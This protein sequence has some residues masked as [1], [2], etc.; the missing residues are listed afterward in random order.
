MSVPE[1]IN[2]LCF[3]LA[4]LKDR[5]NAN[6]AT[7][8]KAFRETRYRRYRDVAFSELLGIGASS[9]RQRGSGWDAV[10]E[11]AEAGYWS[12]ELGR[13]D[14]S[15]R[16]RARAPLNRSREVERLREM[17]LGSKKGEW[18]T[19]AGLAAGANA[20][21][22][23]GRTQSSG[24]RMR[25]SSSI[26]VAETEGGFV[27]TCSDGE[28]VYRFLEKLATTWPE[29]DDEEVKARRVA[30][31]AHVGRSAL[32]D[33]AP[34]A[35]FV[36]G[37]ISI[38]EIAGRAPNVEKKRAGRPIVPAP[39][40][41]FDANAQVPGLSRQR[42]DSL[43]TPTVTP[44]MTPTTT[45][46]TE[47]AQARPFAYQPSRS[48]VKVPIGSLF[49]D[50]SPGKMTAFDARD[51]FVPE[52]SPRKLRRR[53]DEARRGVLD[54][55]DKLNV[56]LP[57]STAPLTSVT[58]FLGNSSLSVV[59]RDL[60]GTS[61]VCK[62]TDGLWNGEESEIA[63]EALLALGGVRS[64]LSKLRGRL[65][66][67]Q[68]LPRPASA[69]ILSCMVES[70][71][72]RYKVEDFAESI[73]KDRD[74][75][76][77]KDPIS[78]AFAHGLKRVLE[79]IDED[80]V[81][82]EMQEVNSWMQP[83]GL[84]MREG[85]EACGAEYHGLGMSILQLEHATASARRSLV[86]LASYIDDEGN[87]GD[88]LDRGES[89]E[90]GEV[91]KRH[92]ADS[93]PLRG[94]A[95]LESLHQIAQYP[96]DEEQ[97]ILAKRLFL[98]SFVPYLSLIS[99][100]AFGI[101][102]LTD[103]DPFV[104]PL[105]SEFAVSAL[106]DTLGPAC[107]PSFFSAEMWSD[108]MVAGTQLRLL[109][110][111]WKKGDEVGGVAGNN[112]ASLFVDDDHGDDDGLGCP[113]EIANQTVDR[114]KARWF[115]SDPPIPTNDDDKSTWEDGVIDRTLGMTLESFDAAPVSFEVSHTP[116]LYQDVRSSVSP[117]SS[118]S[119]M[120]LARSTLL[121]RR[122]L[123]ERMLFGEAEHVPIPVLLESSIG[124][125]IR[126][127][128]VLVSRACVRL[129]VDQQQLNTLDAVR[130]LRNALMGFAGDFTYELVRSLDQ[131]I[132]NL[133][134]MTVH[135]AR[136]AVFVASS[137]SCL[138]DSQYTVHL[139]A[140]LLPKGEDAVSL[141]EDA[142]SY[143]TEDSEAIRIKA[144]YM[145]SMTPMLVPPV[146]HAAYDCIHVSFLAPGLLSAIISEDTLTA[147][148][149][150]FSMTVRLRRAMLA[151]QAVQK[152][153]MMGRRER[154]ECAR[155]DFELPWAER[156]KTFRAFCFSCSIHL[157]AVAQMH[158]ACCSGSA[159]EAV[160]RALEVGHELAQDADEA[161]NNIHALI[162][163]HKRFAYRAASRMTSACN[164]PALKLGLE[165]MMDAL[166]DLRNAV[167]SGGRRAGGRGGVQSIF[168][169]PFHWQEIKRVMLTYE[170]G[171]LGAL[172]GRKGAL[173]P[174]VAHTEKETILR[175]V[176]TA[177]DV[178][179]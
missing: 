83:V 158:C 145:S 88:D 43:T 136:N 172:K 76:R 4:T 91:P 27:F 119:A 178:T 72:A 89:E 111:W 41:W 40:G 74:A 86:F 125:M 148:S 113:S 95:L 114:N 165:M 48:P 55:L 11:A 56:K 123:F 13:L 75:D 82:V 80:L 66:M 151:L 70:S 137:N 34:D 150:I 51:S 142:F 129:F 139:T 65:L 146:G 9:R 116:S 106:N 58:S 94:M 39:R 1:L 99:R 57:T 38:W 173:G 177:L 101:E 73:L 33:D 67:P 157:D 169:D 69:Q 77:A 36:P 12:T 81:R 3:H 63:R 170:R 49:M 126:K 179:W 127:Q 154:M 141:V 168:E 52:K 130:F 2:A 22:R 98:G 115:T 54:D 68:A 53:R 102:H 7:T 97:V 108:L 171:R 120:S 21:M 118:A 90:D 31:G 59:N 10:G 25:P 35:D 103:A 15:D 162:R 64:S 5:E 128:A 132:K 155:G 160:Q 134:P 124:G 164:S 176:F 105:G 163:T 18:D 60:L 50:R 44:S 93:A 161:H 167:D 174:G 46:R 28:R 24:R 14:H 156:F 96:L 62:E 61:R 16:A 30:R 112:V 107:V 37:L 32:L 104:A 19:R 152:A 45:P 100:W 121:T 85:V 17:L 71:E 131:S 153:T 175:D 42:A 79:D 140:S 143:G 26:V 159:W 84:K 29:D 135:K 149:A 110:S 166:L 6:L 92:C 47:L 87:D 117:P 109:Y 78:Y 122:M 147:Y 8:K 23:A 133:E 20:E 138:H 144:P